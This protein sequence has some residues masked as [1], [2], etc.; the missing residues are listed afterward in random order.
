MVLKNLLKKFT[1]LKVT[2]KYL[3]LLF[4]TQFEEDLRKKN[5]GIKFRFPNITNTKIKIEDLIK[6][7][8]YSKNF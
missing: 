6:R 5:L 4:I 8:I 3:D 7:V 1:N 2:K